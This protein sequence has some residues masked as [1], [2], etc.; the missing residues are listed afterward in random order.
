M[1]NRPDPVLFARYSYYLAFA[2][3]AILL[4]AFIISVASHVVQS[5]LPGIL[6]HVVWLALITG[7]VGTFLAYAARSDF[8]RNPGPAEAVIQA[9][10]GWRVNLGAL[11]VLAVSAFFIIIIRLLAVP[12]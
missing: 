4:I 5:D 2:S 9:R 7:G 12:R 3:A 1:S 10:I 8:K 6:I 11:A